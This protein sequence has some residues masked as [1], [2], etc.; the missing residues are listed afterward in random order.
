MSAI[1]VFG[2][3][4]LQILLVLP[5]T[6]LFLRFILSFLLIFVRHFSRYKVLLLSQ[7]ILLSHPVLLRGSLDLAS[8]GVLEAE[9]IC[10][11]LESVVVDI[12]VGLLPEL[13]GGIVNV[14]LLNTIFDFQKHR[15]VFQF[16]IRREALVQYLLLKLHIFRQFVLVSIGIQL[17]TKMLLFTMSFRS[18]IIETSYLFLRVLHF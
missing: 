12:Y 6:L 15:V 13:V 11:A 2:R 4:P 17:E 9:G 1:K 5:L 7:H 16:G 3:L 18:S 8:D 10:L 14:E